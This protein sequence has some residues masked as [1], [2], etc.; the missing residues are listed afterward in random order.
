MSAFPFPDIE[1]ASSE[2]RL[3]SNTGRHSSKFTGKTQTVGRTGER[4]AGRVTLP[5]L[6]GADK[7]RMIAFMS[8]LNGQQHRFVM[9]DHAY[10]KAGAISVSELLDIAFNATNW[11][12]SNSDLGSISDVDVGVRFRV[13]VSSTSTQ[14]APTTAA[15]GISPL[16]AGAS[17]AGTMFAGDPF[18]PP[19]GGTAP[20]TTLRIRDASS[21]IYSSS[22]GSTSSGDRHRAGVTAPSPT[23]VFPRP[24]V[25]SSSSG[26]YKSGVD[27]SGLS[28]ARALLVDN[29]FNALTRSE[30]IDHANWTKL[31]STITANAADAPDG[32]TTAD[33]LVE[34]STASNDHLAYQN[35]TRTSVAEYWT[36][37]VYVQA[38]TSRRI[39]LIVDDGTFSNFGSQFFDATSGAQT[40][41]ASASGTAS[42]AYASMHDVGNG[43][44]RCRLSVR[45]PAT[46]TARLGI[47][48]CDGASNTVSFN[49][50]GTSGLYIWGA[51]LQRGGQLGRYTPTT[52]AAILGTNQSGNTL[53]VKG[54]DEDTDGQLLPG[55]LFEVNGQL[56]R[57]YSQLDG[58]E[59]GCGLLV[60]RPGLRS[61]PADEDPVIL[62]RPHG[63]FMLAN[64]EAAWRNLMAGFGEFSIDFIEDIP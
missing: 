53:W 43:W 18:A 12:I 26:G 31:R 42:N 9:R 25:N 5:P 32:S 57:V 48:L 23:S 29:G 45:L 58:D 62:H 38:N 52:S 7:R 44:Y 24:N 54:L 41:T 6:T 55:D 33:E 50:D 28:F 56:C 14:I 60:F 49:G 34:D 20:N 59:S 4:W 36:G 17:Y 61:A 13:G 16:T 1:G 2:W 3:V 11:E 10:T 27:I 35:Y 15:D 63:T 47:Y 30:E 37:S 51:Q 39:R 19:S 64:P 21:N 46:T 40:G 22:S 8:S